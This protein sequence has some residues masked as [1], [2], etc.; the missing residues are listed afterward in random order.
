MTVRGVM[1]HEFHL[2]LEKSVRRKVVSVVAMGSD[3]PGGCNR[4]RLKQIARLPATCR[5]PA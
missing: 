2:A 4:G 3:T 5:R 1:E